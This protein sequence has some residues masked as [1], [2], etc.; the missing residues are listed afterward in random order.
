MT[1]C[2]ITNLL[3][4][5]LT[6]GIINTAMPLQ[7]ISLQSSQILISATQAERQA[8][9]SGTGAGQSCLSDS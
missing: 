9:Q 6:T 1:S 8:T 5:S 2:Y 4:R 3:Y 7:R